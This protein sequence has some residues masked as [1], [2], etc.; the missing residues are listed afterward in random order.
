MAST[1]TLVWTDD[2]VELL[3]RVTL[4]YKNT[5]SQENIYWES[6]QSKY[7]DIYREYV[8]Q[9]PA[10]SQENG[11]DF[12]HES[13]ITKAQVTSKLKCVRGKYRQAVDSGRRSGHGRVVLIY[14]DLCQQIWGG[15][16]STS[17]LEVGLETADLRVGVSDNTATTSRSST[18]LSEFGNGITY[19]P[20]CSPDPPEVVRERRDGIVQAKLSNHRKDRLK[21]RGHWES[22]VDEDLRLKRRIVDILEES[23]RRNNTR[24]DQIAQN[25]STITETIKEG[26]SLLCTM[27]QTQHDDGKPREPFKTESEF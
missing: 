24:L 20:I 3:L 6:C 10:C 22:A 19:A 13:V 14:Y 15:P 12:P 5:K 23:E 4:D 21:R 26:F 7:Y 16:P 2:E 8:E 17:S 9:Y 11:K 25:V 1:R 27:M 18:P